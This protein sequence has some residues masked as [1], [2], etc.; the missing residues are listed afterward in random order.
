M[1]KKLVGLTLM[2]ILSMSIFLGCENTKETASENSKNET[3]IMISGPKSAVTIPLLRMKETNALGENIKIDLKLYHSMEEMVAIENSK[4][5]GFMTIPVHAASIL[6]N[7]GSN[8]KLLNVGVWG[9]MYL[10]TTDPN[11]NKW[12]ELK[13]KKL[14]VPSK[15]SP[16]DIITQYFLKQHGLKV[17]DNIDIVYS[18]HPEISK[19]IEMGRIK[20][21]VNVEPFV[22]ANKLSNKNLKV[23]F[24]YMDGWKKIQDDQCGLPGFGVVSNNEFL[25]KNKSLVDTF[26]KEYEKAL[27]WTVKNPK[28][29]GILAEK[30]L[31]LDKKLIKKAMPNIPLFYKASTD[32]RKDLEKYYKVLSKFKAKSIGG[33]IPNE[34]FYYTK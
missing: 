10:T 31:K 9:G 23:V 29:A 30:Y 33:K 15:N 19:L 18:T 12:E 27:N 6:Y 13:G 17:G 1:R 21:A 11:C 22:T 28:E 25:A 20:Y 4:K 7:K 14:Y 8:I 24:D 34:D 2:L 26:N 32:A 3:T 16:P 5:Y